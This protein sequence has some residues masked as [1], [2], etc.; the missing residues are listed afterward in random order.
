[1]K[2]QGS[3]AAVAPAAGARARFYGEPVVSP[4][5]GLAGAEQER[6]MTRPSVEATPETNR[7]DTRM[8]RFAFG[9]KA[10]DRAMLVQPL[11]LRYSFVVRQTDGQDR[12]VDTTTVVRDPGTMYLTVE[13]NQEAYLQVWGRTGDSTPQLLFPEKD[14]GQISLRITPGQRQHIQVPTE[15]GRLTIRLS[16]NPFGPV[17]RQ[18]AEMLD[19][20]TAD[21]WVEPI[22]P[23]G[24]PAR[25]EYATYVANRDTSATELSA[26]VSV[27]SKK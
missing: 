23:E 26:D 10:S 20:P 21:Q 24:S 3:P 13:S 12:E 11:A 17:T 5:S 1:M 15:H 16:R 2:T 19:R 7:P 14:T 18:E 4:D 9:S 25:P 27:P 8:E 22:T 6:P